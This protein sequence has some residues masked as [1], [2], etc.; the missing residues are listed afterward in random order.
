MDLY[1]CTRAY[2]LTV[3]TPCH[4]PISFLKSRTF[5]KV[6]PKVKKDRSVFRLI[7]AVLMKKPSDDRWWRHSG[8]LL[9]LTVVAGL[10][11]CLTVGQHGYFRHSHTHYCAI[12]TRLVL[13]REQT[14]DRHIKSQ[15]LTF[16]TTSGRNNTQV[17]MFP[18]QVLFLLCAKQQ[19]VIQDSLMKSS[20]CSTSMYAGSV[21]AVGMCGCQSLEGLVRYFESVTTHLSRGQPI[22]EKHQ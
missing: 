6:S 19:P 7:T 20:N 13:N 10:G 16:Q 9:T 12:F 22:R 4:R 1:Y 21:L 18:N 8:S 14:P 3:R 5:T 17:L 11:Q 15:H 2:A